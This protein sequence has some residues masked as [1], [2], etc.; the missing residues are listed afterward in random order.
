M[1]RILVIVLTLLALDAFPAKAQFT[2]QRSIHIKTLDQ[3]NI[4]AYAMW[5]GGL[6][7]KETS[8]TFTLGYGQTIAGGGFFQAQ[9]SWGK[10]PF[11]SGFLNS[12]FVQSLAMTGPE[13]I[14][15]IKDFGWG[16]NGLGFALN[17]NIGKFNL[18]S[19]YSGY[20]DLFSLNFN[21]TAG[22]FTGKGILI[23]KG[24]IVEQ[25]RSD[26]EVKF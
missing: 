13:Y 19:A 5:S 17:G 15:T 23:M 21:G 11:G 26:I 4:D 16:K 18:G 25:L 3:N 10:T 9:N 12:P 7:K 14:S 24:G 22:D 8:L 20:S 2:N 6:K 1:K